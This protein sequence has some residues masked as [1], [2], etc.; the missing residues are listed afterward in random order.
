MGSVGGASRKYRRDRRDLLYRWDA[1]PATPSYIFPALGNEENT[2]AGPLKSEIAT[3]HLQGY[4]ELS[5][6]A[7]IKPG[8]VPSLDSRTYLSRV[9]SVLDTLHLLRAT[10][11]EYSLLRPFSDS[12]DRIRTINSLRIWVDDAE[13][14]VVLSVGFDRPWEAYLRTVWRDVGTLLD[15]IFCNCEGYPISAECTFDAYGKWISDVRTDTRFFYN[16]SNLSVDDLQ[17]LQ[18]AERI[19]R[20]SLDLAKNDVASTGLVAADPERTAIDTALLEWPETL[21]QGMQALSVLYRLTDLFPPDVPD[22]AVLLRAAQQLLRELRQPAIQAFLQA[23]KPGPA[24]RFRKQLDWFGGVPPTP[25]PP[26]AEVAYDAKN[27]QAGIL[28]N[29]APV[30]THG[31]VLLVTVHE[32]TAGARFVRR[33]REWTGHDG[34]KAPRPGL[35]VNVAFTHAG[36]KKLGLDDVVLADFPVEFREG[37]E[38]RAGMLGDVRGN[39]PGHWTLPLRNWPKP[40]TIADEPLRVSMAAVHVLVQLYVEDRGGPGDHEIAGNPKHPLHAHIVAL[41]KGFAVDVVQLVSVQALRRR[42]GL[43]PN[44]RAR[45]H[46]GFVDG[47]SQPV[48]GDPPPNLD[49]WNNLVRRG[50]ILLGYASTHGD[51]PN[52]HPLLH[53]GS[54]LVVRKLRQDVATLNERLD[55]AA[56]TTGLTRAQ[57]KS[58]MMGRELADGAS[59]ITKKEDNDFDYAGDP[60]GRLCPVHSHV[61]RIN[62]RTAPWSPE[63][64]AQGSPLRRDVPRIMRRGMSYGPAFDAASQASATEDRGLFFMAYNTRIGE[65]FETLQRWVSGPTNSGTYSGEADPFLGV[66]LRGDPRTFRFHDGTKV[67]RVALDDPAAAEAKPFVALQWGAY[68]FAPSLTAIDRIAAIAEAGGST[69]LDDGLVAE[70]AAIVDGLLARESSL[71]DE[72]AI[73]AWKEL[74]E[75]NLPR[76]TRRAQAA[77]AAIRAHHGGALRTRYGVLVASR[78]LV[79]QVFDDP[80]GCYSVKGYRECMR[81][82]FGE[83]YLGL[84]AGARYTEES[85]L[86]NERILAI[87]MKDGFE[88]GRRAALGKLEKLIGEA[89]AT[90]YHVTKKKRWEVTFDVRELCDHVL[91]DVNKVWFDLPDGTFIK[92]GGWF[93]EMK[94]PSCPGH[95]TAP[96]RYIFQPHPG[97]EAT[98]HGRQQG[99]Q[100]LEKMHGWVAAMRQAQATLMGLIS[101]PLFEHLPDTPEGNDLL[102]RTL[103]GVMMGYLPTVDANLKATLAEWMDDGTLWALQSALVEDEKTTPWGRVQRV[104][105]PALIHTMQLR[106]LPELTW[107]IATKTH[108]LGGT[109]VAEGELVVIGMVSAVQQDR[110]AHP[111]PDPRDVYPVFGGYRRAAQHPTH[112]CPGYEAGMGVLLGAFTALC[113]IGTLLPTPAPLTVRLRGPTKKPPAPP[114]AAPPP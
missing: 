84:D 106:P 31:A 11:R 21:T 60:D 101:K 22:G 92:P 34:G 93:W 89:N 46:F 2:M 91:A 1:A 14:F 42:H 77:W 94:E 90:A 103:I 58:R 74:L 16:N 47:T 80:H 107:R 26:P 43:G 13:R 38:T 86:A 35:H 28:S 17:V 40:I 68:L 96:S 112:A 95:F 100:V 111:A 24:A 37:M 29:H 15:L 72:G 5:L 3:R 55:A 8:F 113:E 62:Q 109:R 45:E 49:R 53:D 104:M 56:A 108:Q 59:P 61:R 30:L 105:L 75:D 41:M 65:Q 67:Q 18:Q 70:G 114:A 27:V 7:P 64:P 71:D 98:R 50:D 76:R 69:Q 23:G 73:A 82:S 39:H 6:R 110:M 32:R 81:R 79:M 78:E 48:V 33:V 20:D 85:K 51:P 88:A 44:N 99:Q 102:A 52:E 83:I 36:L 12:T 66:P 63:M 97:P 54:F 4:S 57:I 87:R 9:K 19:Q 10:S 25:R